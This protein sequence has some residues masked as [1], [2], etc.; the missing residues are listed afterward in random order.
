MRVGRGLTLAL[1]AGVLVGPAWGEEA[2]G[3]PSHHTD[4]GFRNPVPIDRGGVTVTVP[5]L[6]R[7]IGGF[8]R[9][10]P[11]APSAI[12]NDGA[13]LRDNARH[14]K[15]TVTWVGHATLLVQMDHVSF[16][17]DPTWSHTASPVS[18]VGPRRFVPPALPFEALPPIDLVVISHNHYDH[19]DLT[20]LR[21][22][23]E[24]GT[25]FL[26]PL[27]VGELLR[28]EGIGPVE[29]LDWWDQ[30]RIAGVDV[31]CVPARHWSG[32]GIGDDSATLWSGWVV[33]GPTRRFYF[34]GDTGYFAGFQ[35]IG[36]RLGPIGLAALPI[37]AYE[38]AAMMRDVHLNPE[39]AVQ[40][41]VDLGAQRMI[42]VH[43]GTFDLTDEPL[44][45]PPRRFQAEAVRRGLTSQVWTPPLGEVRVW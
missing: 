26:V 33:V 21:R 2:M 30:R 45:E 8:F 42:G 28:G 17:T 35:E 25:R 15:P 27:R 29:E 19:L 23:A 44:D 39:E 3:R 12:A 18:F 38:P 41:G 34:A 36:R 5:F 11:G 31:H 9:D 43:Y 10:R 20:T 24:R 4:D 14:S 16:L 1:L 13:F 7:R 37:G 40:A 6:V 32:R 22:L